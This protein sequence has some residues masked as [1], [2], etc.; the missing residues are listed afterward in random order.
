MQPAAFLDGRDTPGEPLFGHRANDMFYEMQ[1][2]SRAI[3]RHYNF[4]E[5]GLIPEL[6]SKR[7]FWR[8]RRMAKSCS[9][10][11]R[12]KWARVVYIFGACGR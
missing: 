3:A 6:V 2:P 9:L 11:S 12:R 8:P 5:M 4:G 7:F 10:L 1:L